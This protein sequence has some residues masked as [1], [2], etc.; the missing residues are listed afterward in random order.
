MS[1]NSAWW[2][3]AMGYF[4]LLLVECLHSRGKQPTLSRRRSAPPGSRSTGAREDC[5]TDRLGLLNEHLRIV[6]EGS[7]APIDSCRI[8]DCGDRCGQMGQGDASLNEIALVSTRATR[9]WLVWSFIFS[10]ASGHHQAV[11]QGPSRFDQGIAA[12][13]RAMAALS[14]PTSKTIFPASHVTR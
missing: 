7:A 9:I 5:R 10:V 14:L 8:R 11:A 3:R 4:D 6:D 13:M 2:L 1:R 12:G